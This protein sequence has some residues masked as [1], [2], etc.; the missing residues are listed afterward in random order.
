[1]SRAFEQTAT[2]T[3]PYEM[4]ERIM[5]PTQRDTKK[6]A[7][8]R[9]RRLQAQERLAR[10]RRQAQR[11]AEALQ[12][13]LDDLG[14]PE[15]LATEIAGRLRSQQQLLSKIVGMMC[16]RCLGAVPTL[17][18]VACGAGTRTCLRGYSMRCPNA[19]GSSG[20]DA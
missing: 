15:D 5:S 18:S 14:L 6:Q 3:D 20:F 11:A 1:V 17:N 2:A 12:Q 8:A 7:K 16:P 9:P 10:D 4:K 19:P 13:A